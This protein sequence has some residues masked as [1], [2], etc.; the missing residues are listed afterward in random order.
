MP[1]QNDG[2][3]T[4]GWVLNDLVPVP[5]AAVGYFDTAPVSF[6]EGLCK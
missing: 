6:N 3:K 5:R 2:C 1:S 4:A